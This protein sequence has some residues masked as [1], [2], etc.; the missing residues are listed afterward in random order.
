MA[1]TLFSSNRI[2]SLQQRLAFDLAAH[3]PANP[4]SPETIIVPTYAMGRWLNLRLAQQRGIAANLDYP[5]PMQWIWSLAESQLGRLPAH[6]H[7]SAEALAWDCFE[8]LPEMMSD[9]AFDPIRRYL[10]D[11]K[12]GQ[13]QWQ[14][15]QRLGLSLIHI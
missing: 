10:G 11:D 4:L 3:P 13:K 15:S 14:L 2:E 5:Q 8:L 7:S 1:L 12:S 9:S 6:D